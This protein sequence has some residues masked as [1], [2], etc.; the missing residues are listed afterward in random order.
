VQ[1]NQSL[2]TA[3]WSNGQIS[4]AYPPGIPIGRVSSTDA[5]D[6]QEFQ[7]IHVEP[8]ADLRQL[9]YVQVLTGGDQRPGVPG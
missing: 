7:R 1:A 3:G 6:Q 5:G 2:A 8:F 4:S 9:G